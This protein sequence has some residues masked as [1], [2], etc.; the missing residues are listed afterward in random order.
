MMIKSLIGLLL[1]FWVLGLIFDIAG[2]LVDKV[3]IIV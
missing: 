1:L 2:G 3:H